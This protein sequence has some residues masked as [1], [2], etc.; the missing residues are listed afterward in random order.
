M[1]PVKKFVTWLRRDAEIADLRKRLADAEWKVLKYEIEGCK[2]QEIDP[3]NIGHNLKWSAY[4]L[5]KRYGGR[6]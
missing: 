5:H 6:S 1:N 3:A 4:Y 2:P